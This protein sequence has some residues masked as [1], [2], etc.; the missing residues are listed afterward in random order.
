MRVHRQDTLVV[1]AIP[2]SDNSKVVAVLQNSNKSWGQGWVGGIFGAIR[3]LL[4]IGTE[5]T[6]A[7]STSM[8]E[9]TGSN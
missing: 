1:K 9:A 2:K 6:R 4:D 7:V 5:A 8:G 3:E